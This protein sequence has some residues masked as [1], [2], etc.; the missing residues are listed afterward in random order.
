MLLGDAGTWD[1]VGRGISKKLNI[2]SSTAS[3]SVARGQQIVEEQELELL[4]E[5]FK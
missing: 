5:E 2:A 4:D 1:E 3:E